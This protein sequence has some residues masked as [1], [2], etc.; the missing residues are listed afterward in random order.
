MFT[1]AASPT[2][3]VFTVNNSLVEANDVVVVNLKAGSNN[4]YVF[5]VLGVAAGSF[6]VQ[7]FAAAGTNSDTPV[8]SFNVFKGVIV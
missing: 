6:G 1:A 4:N 5:T 7:F 3:A 2:P 8:L